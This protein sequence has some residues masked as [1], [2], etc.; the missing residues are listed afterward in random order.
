MLPLYPFIAGI[1]VG[2][3]AV[4]LYR[5]P[6]ARDSLKDARQVLKERSAQAQ[7]TL[8]HAAMVGLNRIESSTARW[9]DRLQAAPDMAE[10]PVDAEPVEAVEASTGGN[11]PVS[12]EKPARRAHKQALDPA[13]TR[14]KPGK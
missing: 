10:G 1:V 9:R 7:E 8:R 5:N 12:A 3:V 14:E 13:A 6:K 2:A 4:K 11:E